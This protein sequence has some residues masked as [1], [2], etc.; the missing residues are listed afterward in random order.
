[1][2]LKARITEDMKTA[3]KAKESLEA[4]NVRL[5]GAIL[6]ER[7]FPIPEALYRIL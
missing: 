2:T 6:S 1:M 7:T 5:L 3:M 4:S